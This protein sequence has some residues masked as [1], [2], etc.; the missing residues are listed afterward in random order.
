[1]SKKKYDKIKC[2][3]C[4]REVKLKK[5]INKCECGSRYKILYY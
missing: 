4:G 2:N 5:H 3:E 1:M